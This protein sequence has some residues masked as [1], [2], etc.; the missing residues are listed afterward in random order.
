[1]TDSERLARQLAADDVANGVIA[2]DQFER[3]AASYARWLADQRDAHVRAMHATCDN[4][5]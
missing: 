3:Q 4:D 5:N 2:A 1:M